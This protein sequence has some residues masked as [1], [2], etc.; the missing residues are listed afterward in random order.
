M[1]DK[2]LNKAKFDELIQYK[3]DIMPILGDLSWERLDERRACRIAAY[4]E[5]TR[6]D[7]MIDWGVRTLIAFKDTFMK[8]L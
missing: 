7:A 4:T 5:V 6:E 1:N 8:Y 2:E 3:E